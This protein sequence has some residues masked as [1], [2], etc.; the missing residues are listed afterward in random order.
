MADN[1]LFTDLETGLK[2][3]IDHATGKQKAKTTKF[4][5]N[6]NK[7]DKTEF[8]EQEVASQENEKLEA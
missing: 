4:E 8:V 7:I 3:A 1:S 2:Q 5:E 6:E